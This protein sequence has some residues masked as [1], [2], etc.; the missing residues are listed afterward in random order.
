MTDETLPVV[1]PPSV[2]HGCES[3]AV[4][5]IVLA[6]GTSSR[7]GSKNKLLQSIDGDPVIRR[8]VTALVDS[9]L[10]DVTVVLGYDRERVRAALQGFDIEFRYNDS[11]EDGQSTS[12]REGTTAA[13]ETNAD[14][15][16]FALGDMP[17]VSS[18]TIDTLVTVYESETRSAVA[19]GYRGERGNPVLFDSRHFES[20]GSVSGDVGGRDILRRDPNA[21]V[22]E[23]GDPGVLRDIDRPADLRESGRDFE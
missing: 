13:R 4:H 21:V 20:L 10:S 3:T 11:Y 22:V 2:E 6:A 17:Y 16:L 1:E 8:A 7:Y 12:V 19:A 18:T 15:V 23:T 5:G 9:R 14:A